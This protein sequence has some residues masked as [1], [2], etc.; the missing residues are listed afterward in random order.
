MHQKGRISILTQASFRFH[1]CNI[2]LPKCKSGFVYFL[3]SIKSK[4]Y[5]YIGEYN[6]IVSRLYNHNCGHGSSSTTPSHIR[7]F[8][9]L[10][11]IYGFDGG[12]RSLRNL[13]ELNW[14]LKRDYLICNG[15]TDPISWIQT[16]STV[17]SE[18][19]N[20]F[21]KKER[22]ELRLVQSFKQ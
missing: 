21:Y 19:N 12:N 14:K 20:K 7:P 15:S 5:T 1:I 8:A 3:I 18:L 2:S 9:I 10:G 16:D 13:I 22:T 11:L 4:D 17:I 6:C